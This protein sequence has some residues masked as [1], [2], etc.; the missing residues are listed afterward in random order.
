MRSPSALGISV[1]VFALLV[2]IA[3]N[4]RRGDPHFIS[5]M[6]DLLSLAV[7]W[8]AMFAAMRTLT[9]LPSSR[10]EPHRAS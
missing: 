1:G 6:P 3:G 9:S 4:L 8:A 7:A 2:S 10:D 5:G